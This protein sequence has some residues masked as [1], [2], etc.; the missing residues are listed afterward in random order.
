MGNREIWK[1]DMMKLSG[2]PGKCVAQAWLRPCLRDRLMMGT[3][4]E[5]P[6]SR[7]LLN[8]HCMLSSSRCCVY[9][10]KDIESCLPEWDRISKL[11]DKIQSILDGDE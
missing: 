10:D 2:R 4:R 6:F 9:N 11:I 7:Y 3:G 8:A 1:V 5:L